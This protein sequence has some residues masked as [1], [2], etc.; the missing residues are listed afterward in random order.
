MIKE[1]IYKK[2]DTAEV[3]WIYT[4]DFHL[5]A[6]LYSE[7]TLGGMVDRVLLKLDEIASSIHKGSR[8]PSHVE[9]TQKLR[10]E[11]ETVV[12]KQGIS[13]RRAE[14]QKPGDVSGIAGVKPR[15]SIDGG[16]TR[17]PGDVSGIAG[18]KPRVSIDGGE[19]PETRGRIRDSRSQT[20]GIDTWGRDP[21]TRGRIRDSRS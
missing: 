2:T 4:H 8:V 18:V 3:Q 6:I 14:I 7:D 20:Q 21:E 19:T 9:D 17:K 12:D 15:V 13:L 16:E 11:F 10:D 1:R 5:F